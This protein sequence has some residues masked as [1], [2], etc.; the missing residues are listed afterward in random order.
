MKILC[1]CERG[2][3][4]SVALAYLF[5]DWLGQ[6]ALSMGITAS[7]ED[8]K[9]MLYEWAELGQYVAYIQQQVRLEGSEK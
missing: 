5:K 6:D 1:I 2:N 4:R 3:S 9:R 8:T 7:S